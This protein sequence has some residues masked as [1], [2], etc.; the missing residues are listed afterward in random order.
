MLLLF[1]GSEVT[2]SEIKTAHMSGD[3]RLVF[4]RRE[5]KSSVSLMLDGKDIDTRNQCHSVWEEM[6]TKHPDNLREAIKAATCKP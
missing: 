6:W 3:T 5:G 4:T 2:E 1:D